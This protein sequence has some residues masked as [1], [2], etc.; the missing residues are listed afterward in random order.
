MR[1]AAGSIARKYLATKLGVRIQGYVSKVGALD[2]HAVDP[3]SAYENPFFCPD[4][5]RL[6]ELEDLIWKLRS[7]GDSDGNLLID[8]WELLFLGMLGS[9]PFGDDDKDGYSNLQEMM[10]GTDPH[11]TAG[12]PPVPVAKLNVPVLNIEQPAAGAVTLAWQRTTE[13]LEE[14]LR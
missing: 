4:P 11:D 6:Q 12:A 5:S 10:E 2:N 7:D 8:S 13:F 1:V 9:D 14:Q 3:E